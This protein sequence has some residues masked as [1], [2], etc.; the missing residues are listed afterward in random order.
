MSNDHHSS[1]N[2]RAGV[3]TGYADE[4]NYCRLRFY[5]PTFVRLGKIVDGAHVGL[6]GP[7]VTLDWS[8]DIEVELC[9]A[10]RGTPDGYINQ[11][12]QVGIP[13]VRHVMSCCGVARRDAAALSTIDAAQK[14]QFVASKLK[15][16]LSAIWNQST[17]KMQ[18]F[19]ALPAGSVMHF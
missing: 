10:P 18:P 5:E 9:Y 2:D 11:V 13:P 7:N 16:G 17:K 4:L 19:R 14:G 6:D 3:I 15:F 1:D 12:L 8:N